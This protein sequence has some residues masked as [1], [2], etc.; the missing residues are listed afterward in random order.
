M[1]EQEHRVF[2][3]LD[4][5]A[6]AFAGEYAVEFKIYRAGPTDSLL[7]TGT[8]KWDGC[9]DWTTDEGFH[10]C[11]RGQLVAIGEAMARCWD[12]ASSL[13]PGGLG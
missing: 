3:D 6:V 12:W 11:T 7:L 5:Q 8:V 2:K 1:D 9:S 13:F 10:A 4:L